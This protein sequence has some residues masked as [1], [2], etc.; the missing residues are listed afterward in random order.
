MT[1]RLETEVG[2]KKQLLPHKDEHKTA[3]EV[4]C[5]GLPAGS[6][7]RYLTRTPDLGIAKRTLGKNVSNCL[8]ESCSHKSRFSS[9]FPF[10]PIAIRGVQLFLYTFWPLGGFAPKVEFHQRQLVDH[11][12]PAYREVNYE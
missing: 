12:S 2:Q 8:F 3:R 1:E 5:T 10:L 9:S 11:S 7:G 6:L 4:A